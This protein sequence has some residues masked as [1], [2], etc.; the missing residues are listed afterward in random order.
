MKKTRSGFTLVELLIVIVIIAILAAIT[1]VAYNG[2]QNRANDSRR[3]QDLAQIKRALKLYQTDNNDTFPAS[4]P[5]PGYSSWEISTDPG[6]L[7]SLDKYDGATT[8]KDPNNGQYRYHTFSA[9]SY[10]CPASMGAYY[11]IWLTGMQAQPAGTSVLQTN[12][13]T[14][15]TLVAGGNLTKSQYYFYWG[16][17]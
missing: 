1:I 9:G 11:V 15:Q 12:G 5:N 7:S 2:I 10:G 14:G 6:F 4:V 16:S 3:M 13:C 17:L 8:F